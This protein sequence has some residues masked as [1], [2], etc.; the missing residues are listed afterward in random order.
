MRFAI[1]RP[2]LTIVVAGI[3]A[4]CHTPGATA[5]D[6]SPVGSELALT[7]TPSRPGPQAG[8]VQTDELT[9]A[10]VSNL[11]D[12]LERVRPEFLRSAQI[13]NMG[14]VETVAPTVFINGRY[15]GERDILKLVQVAE[16]T[17]VKLLRPSM[18]RFTFGP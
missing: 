2:V 5:G 1:A 10:N 8:R 9:G 16:V 17:E 14:H 11:L 12:A 4:A 7:A 13:V 15:A 6:P 3:A 18:A